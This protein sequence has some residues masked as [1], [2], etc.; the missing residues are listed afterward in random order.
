MFLAGSYHN[1]GVLE[2]VNA[3]TTLASDFT[4]ADLR[5]F[6]RSGGTVNLR[7][8]LDNRGTTLA[9]DDTTGPWNLTTGGTILG[10]T[11]ATAGSA[12]LFAQ[13]LTSGGTLDGVTV[14]GTLDMTPPGSFLYVVHSLTLNGTLHTANTV[15]FF[16]SVR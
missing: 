4:L 2:A 9:L 5:V 10:G 7:A 14:N 13:P 15:R 11:V 1:A 12:R 6:H 3:T 16:V 8:T